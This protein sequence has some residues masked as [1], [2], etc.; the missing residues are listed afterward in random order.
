MSHDEM[1]R[2]FLYII[3][4]PGSAYMGVQVWNAVI[5]PKGLR[6]P[7]AIFLWAQAAIYT[8]FMVG[9]FL[10]RLYHPI[11][12]LVWVNTGFILIQALTIVLAI[13]KLLKLRRLKILPALLLL[14]FGLLMLG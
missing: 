7:V 5:M 10:L 6:R 1:L 2:T 14:A 3:I 4:I 11:Q 9:L 12:G 13:V 8:M